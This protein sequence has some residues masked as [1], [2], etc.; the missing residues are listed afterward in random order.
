MTG[1]PAGNARQELPSKQQIFAQLSA[2]EKPLRERGLRSLAIFGSYV[3]GAA[4]S[5]SD[6]D[7]L[8][9]V[10]PDIQFSLVDLV[11]IKD[12]LEDSLGRPVDVVTKY[13]LEPVI[14]DSVLRE[15]ETVF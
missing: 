1:Q 10:A 7:V 3:R 13:G 15:A 12:Y 8:V 11:S 6:V 2:L 5:D 14:R 4:R 9:E